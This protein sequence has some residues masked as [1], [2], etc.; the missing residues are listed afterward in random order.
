MQQLTNRDV[1]ETVC[2]WASGIH[3]ATEDKPLANFS[4]AGRCVN[5]YDDQS[6]TVVKIPHAELSPDVLL[7]K[8]DGFAELVYVDKTK[9]IFGGY[10]NPIIR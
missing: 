1:I 6:R 8:M 7:V 2:P 4:H 9:L 10:K 3:G 5:Y